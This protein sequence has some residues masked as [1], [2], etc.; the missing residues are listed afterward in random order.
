MR[1]LIITL[2]AVALAFGAH[3]QMH[4]TP[5]LYTPH[6]TIAT[7]NGSEPYNFRNRVSW[8]ASDVLAVRL[9]FAYEFINKPG[10]IVLRVPLGVGLSTNIFD[11]EQPGINT[12]TG[13]DINIYPKT[14][15]KPYHRFYPH[16]IFGI[17]VGLNLR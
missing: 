10:T 1:Y 8:V 13:L 17:S 16:G 5:V 11:W 2:I 3:A 6:N 9:M 7:K 14:S 12:V 15:P 4:V